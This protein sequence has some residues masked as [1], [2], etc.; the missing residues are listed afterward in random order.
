MPDLLRL[1]GRLSDYPERVRGQVYL[2]DLPADTVAALRRFNILVP[3]S[4]PPLEA[5]PFF[6]ER[7]EG[8]QAAGVGDLGALI[9]ADADTVA[10]IAAACDVTLKTVK[11][12]QGRALAEL[13]P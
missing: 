6:A 5:V 8:M 11:D 10:A 13:S 1:N 9:C 4:P 12:W 2:W 7:A 3:V